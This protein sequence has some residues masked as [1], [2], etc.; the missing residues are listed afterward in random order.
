MKLL[1]LVAAYW[2]QTNRK[3]GVQTSSWWKQQLNLYEAVLQL[4][5]ANKANRQNG[6]A[7][8]YVVK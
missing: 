1:Q 3:N 8:I 4:A 7:K 5:A 2:D 6:G